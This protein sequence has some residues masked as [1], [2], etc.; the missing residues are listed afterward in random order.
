MITMLETSFDHPASG[1]VERISRT[2]I[3]GSIFIFAVGFLPF[4]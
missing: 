1:V 4:S 3:E 2:F